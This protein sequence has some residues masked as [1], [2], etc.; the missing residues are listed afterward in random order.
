MKAL[1]A[2]FAVASIAI[3]ASQNE[4]ECVC[5]DCSRCIECIECDA[6]FCCDNCECP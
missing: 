2:V 4:G 3:F 5:C 6:D 1:I